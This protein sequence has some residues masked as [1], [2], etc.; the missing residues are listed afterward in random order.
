[1]GALIEDFPRQPCIVA[2]EM[3]AAL[4]LHDARLAGVEFGTQ[5]VIVALSVNAQYRRC[6]HAL[7][8]GSGRRT[9][10]IVGNPVTHMKFEDRVLGH[11]HE[12]GQ[13]DVCPRGGGKPIDGEG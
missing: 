4:H 10:I 13:R 1:L 9:G 7:D 12:H 6:A 5:R 3:V 2:V 8:L 11:A